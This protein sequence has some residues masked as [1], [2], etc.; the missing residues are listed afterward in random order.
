MAGKSG[1]STKVRPEGESRVVIP[2]NLT[3][4]EEGVT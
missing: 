2:R 1:G 4:E 3:D